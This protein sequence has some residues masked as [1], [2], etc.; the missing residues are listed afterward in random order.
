MHLHRRRTATGAT[1]RV[2]ALVAAT[3]CFVLLAACGA[4][5]SA[6]ATAPPSSNPTGGET[7]T[8]VP[9]ASPSTEAATAPP[10]QEWTLPLQDGTNENGDV[11]VTCD[12]S[13]TLTAG[14]AWATVEQELVSAQAGT[15]DAY[16]SAS[17]RYLP[18]HP[19]LQWTLPDVVAM[20]W[21]NGLCKDET[22]ATLS[23]QDGA[24]CS[25]TYDGSAFV[26]ANLIVGDYFVSISGQ[27]ATTDPA[28]T[29]AMANILKTAVL[30][31]S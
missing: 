22:P 23:G 29:A 31:I 18:R 25:Y 8:T 19:D 5:P 9:A 1:V 10:P 20:V 30:T 6:A 15:I 17:E 24:I 13:V 21:S 28:A 27:P 16:C 14:G 3:A 7:T 4:H 11:G 26:V 12:G 2:V